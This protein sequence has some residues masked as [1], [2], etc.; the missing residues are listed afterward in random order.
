M[1]DTKPKTN[2]PEPADQVQP[3][4]RRIVAVHPGYVKSHDG[5]T[6]YI[7]ADRL[8]Q[9]HELRT[10]WI[11][12]DHKRP[13]TYRGR[14]WSDYDHVFPSDSGNYGRNSAYRILDKHE[15]FQFTTKVRRGFVCINSWAGREE[16]PCLIIGETRKRYRIK[17]EQPTALPPKWKILHPGETK[18]VPKW[19][20]KIRRAVVS[21]SCARI[22]CSRS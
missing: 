19:A 20:V 17:V 4:V 14:R 12:W 7:T 22:G 10:G 3:L 8:A 13:D 21:A 2:T 15:R 9:L 16:K 18:L 1:S 11:I 5:D 6:H